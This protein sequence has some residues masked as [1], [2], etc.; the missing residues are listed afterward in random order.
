MR[1][2]DLLT[3]AEIRNAK[4]DRG[5]F[6]KRLLD[7]DGLY[8]QVTKSTEGFNRN[9]IFRYEMDGER[10]DM[11]LGPLHRVSLAE[12]R[13]KKA[14][15]RTA[16]AEGIDPLQERIDL[17][18]ERLAKKAKELKVKTFKQCTEAYYKVHQRNLKNEKYRRQWLWNM[19]TYVFPTIGEL[20][21]ADIDTAHIEKTLEPIW[22]T[23]GDT[24]SKIQGQIKKVF[25]WAIAGKYRIG[26][27]PARREYITALLSKPKLDKNHHA[28]M[29]VD[30]AP[31]FLA[32]LRQ[33]NRIAARALEFAVLTCART[34]EIVGAKWSEFDLRARQWVIP[35]ERMKIKSGSGRGDHRVPLSDRAMQILGSLKHHRR[36][37]DISNG[38]MLE[39]L[40]ERHPGL[41]VHGFRSTFRDWA[42]ERTNYPEFIVE[43][44]LDHAVGTDVVKAYRRTDLFERRVRLMKQWGDFLAKPRPATAQTVDL[45]AERQR[46]SGKLANA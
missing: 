36:V 2:V 35:R 13:R 29:K 4:P 38:A 37:F 5:K 45:Q 40:K 3:D 31:A 16:I 1:R 34:E 25:D 11:G 12:A 10:H 43:M 24:A 7:G 17:R 44:A 26:D 28:A 32:E 18:K 14:D 42:A 21:V 19:Q 22:S 46:R 20:N 15:L 6:V 27:N 39:L 33:D 23:I 41:T 8:L 9:W 30:D